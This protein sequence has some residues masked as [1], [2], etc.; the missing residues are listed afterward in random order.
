MPQTYIFT[1]SPCGTNSSFFPESVLYIFIFIAFYQSCGISHHSFTTTHRTQ[2]IGSAGFH[3]HPSHLDA[4]GLAEP[5][6][7]RVNIISQPGA[8]RHDD[9]IYVDQTGNVFFAG[10]TGSTDF[11]TTPGAFQAAHGGDRDAVVVL[12]SAD[13]S[14]LLYST[15]MGGEAYDAGR[16]ACFGP[17]GDLYLTGATNG[18][19]WPVRNAFQATFAGTNDGRWGNGDCIL[20]RFRRTTRAEERGAPAAADKLRR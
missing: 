17:R 13:F 5:F 14:R 12:L 3:T 8:F 15:Y 20:A 11:P 16:S 10:L 19:G 4:H 1:S 2:A 9:G 18:P 6:S 7:Y